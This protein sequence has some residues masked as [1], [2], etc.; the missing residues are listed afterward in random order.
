MREFC[1][2]SMHSELNL[3][4]SR[5]GYKAILGLRA[6]GCQGQ[7]RIDFMPIQ[8]LFGVPRS[9]TYA[10]F[11]QIGQK[12]R[13]LLIRGLRASGCQGPGQIDFMPIETLFGVPRST[14]YSIFKKIGQ[15]VRYLLI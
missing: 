7:G 10:I 11:K 4:S 15:K 9:T 5:T 13:Y 3:S 2:V 6:P 1:I 8:T 14:T 12:V